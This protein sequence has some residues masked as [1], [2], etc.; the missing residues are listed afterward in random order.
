M[1]P[2]IMLTSKER[3]F[4]ECCFPYAGKIIGRDNENNLYLKQCSPEC[5]NIVKIN[6]SLFTFIKPTEE[7]Y[8]NRL[9]WLEYQDST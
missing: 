1:K 7:W 8:I 2:D 6:S 3:Q 5:T 4:L 9:I